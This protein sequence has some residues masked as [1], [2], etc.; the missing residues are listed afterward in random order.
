VER[1]AM[2]MIHNAGLNTIGAIDQWM[3]VI[4]ANV[5]GSTVTGFRGSKVEFGNVLEMVQRGS[6][7]PTDGYGSVNP[8]QHADSG[9][10][11]KGTTTDFSQGTIQETGNP[12]NL[13]INGDA[14]FIV[15][16]VP[17]PRSN[18]DVFFTRNGDFHF[19][20]LPGDLRDAE[21]KPVAGVG[22]YRLV[23]S[24]GM[25]VQGFT[26]PVVNVQRPFGTPPE[27]TSGVDVTGLS[28]LTVGD[29]PGQQP[30]RVNLQN[31]QLDL[32]RNPD[33]ANNITFTPQGLLMV[34]GAEPIDLANNQ[35]NMHV[36]LAKFNNQQG[37]DRTGGGAYF[38]YDTVAGE[39]TVGVAGTGNGN[40]QD[41]QRARL[42]GDKNVLTAGAL[43]NSNTS[44]NTTMP[45]I[46][47]AQ[48]SFS[49]ATKIISVGNTMIDD[50][51][52]LIR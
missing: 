41:G 15:S 9:I 14:F 52:G 51:N 23:N 34:N 3:K 45:E 30:R 7:K 4:S 46:T 44:I 40:G 49:A 25:F 11:I 29:A 26:S 16:R 43:E 39:I 12:T 18:D 28:A 1:F 50:A 32:A 17:V 48:K 6:A 5:T 19:E 13:A 22:T 8:I 10:M 36:A 38:Q 21:G 24:D 20:F 37:L 31:I 42:I 2:S 27:E 35:A 33:A 47:L